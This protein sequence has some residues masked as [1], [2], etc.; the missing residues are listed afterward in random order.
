MVTC[1]HWLFEE[2][3][4][5]HFW[6]QMSFSLHCYFSVRIRADIPYGLEFYLGVPLNYFLKILKSV[7]VFPQVFH[8][9]T[10]QFPPFGLCTCSV[11]RPLIRDKKVAVFQPDKLF[12]VAKEFLADASQSLNIHF[13]NVDLPC[14]LPSNP[15]LKTCGTAN[16]QIKEAYILLF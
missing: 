11:R 13:V 9:T 16:F 3:G 2:P 4:S 5:H 6:L 14:Y 10:L 12:N 8:T 7:H 1:K 15:L